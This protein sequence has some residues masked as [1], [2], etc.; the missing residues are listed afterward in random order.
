V[1][2]QTLL[3]PFQV[4]VTLLGADVTADGNFLYAADNQRGA[5]QGVIHKVDLTT[6]AVTELA[7]DANSPSYPMGAA[8][9]P[10]GVVLAANGKGFST[11]QPDESVLSVP[12]FQ[13]DPTTG[14]VTVRPDVPGGSTDTITSVARSADRSLL[15]FADGPNLQGPI[16]TYNSATDTFS[17][18][19]NTGLLLN[20]LPTAVNRNGTLVALEKGDGSLIVADASTFN[21]VKTLSGIDS[22]VAFDPTRDVLYGVDSATD[23]IVAFNTNTWAVVFTL[24]VGEPVSPPGKGVGTDVL[25]VSGDG[26]YLFLDT[27]SGVRVYPVPT[28]NQL[29][30]G[31]FTSPTTA[32]A[33]GSIT[34]TAQDSNGNVL[35]GYAGTVQF[36]STDPQA[37]LPKDY[38]F[39]PGDNGTHTF[40]GVVLRTA[41]TQSINVTDNG[42]PAL[43]GG[44]TNITVNAAAAASLTLSGVPT[45]FPSGAV[46]SIVV[47]AKDAYGNVAT[48]YT[49]K[50]R[51]TSTDPQ[52]SA[53]SGLPAGYT[54]TTGTGGD[55][56]SHT[57][58]NGLS[59]KTL[60][61]QTVTVTDGTLQNTASANVIGGA[62]TQLVVAV[63]PPTAVGP[64]AAFSLTVSAEDPNGNVDPLFT[65][66]VSLAL[67]SNP[68]G[69]TLGGTTIMNA[70]KGVAAFTGL[71]LD[72]TGTG[73]TI[74]ATAT[75]L[76]TAT[77]NPFD[78]DTLA[79]S[80]NTVPEFRPVGTLVGTLTTPGAG[81]FT[82]SLPNGSDDNDKFKISGNQLQTNDAFAAAAKSS[83]SVLVTSTDGQGPPVQQQFTITVTPDSALSLS[84]GTLTVSGKPGNDAFSF[85]AGLP[86]DG[87]TLDG[88]ALAVDA[89]SVAQ[90]GVVFNGGG[91]TDSATLFAGGGANA[92][93]LAPGGGTLSGPGGQVTVNGVAQV[94]VFGHAN[95][96]ATFYGSAG[97]D[98]FMGTPAF[99]FLRGAG[100]WNQANG[101]GVAV[102]VGGGGSDSAYLYG[103][104]GNDAF[105]GNPDYAFLNGAGFWN[106]VN[107]F[108]RVVGTAGPGGNDTANLAGAAQGGNT[109]VGTP[110]YGYLFGA[111]FLDFAAGFQ[112]VA[113][114]AAGPNNAA[115]LIG[116]AAGVNTLTATPAFA[117]LSGPGYLNYAAGFQTVT[118]LAGTANDVAQ[119]FDAPGG[120]F[121]ATATSAYV[122]AGAGQV[123]QAVGFRMVYGY[124]GGGDSAFLYGTMS[125][126][127]TYVNNGSYAFLFGPGFFVLESGFPSV[128]ANPFA[129]R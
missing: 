64:G 81:P 43:S 48:G 23:Q 29:I 71:T 46:A 73:Y 89:A 18:P 66:S 111:G 121:V 126:A 49:G 9:A 35:T 21:V 61:N 12:L 88:T 122:S 94:V 116:S 74:Q 55:N 26:K 24:A 59:L 96:R 10:Y 90:G 15:F 17:K 113:A 53:G 68:G 7:Y 50:V 124:S 30:V 54:F 58:T 40:T 4:G 99:A 77:T 56:G 31:G 25:A 3:A 78:V 108:S 62:A 125:A 105:V 120:M 95:D 67:A 118:A 98:V 97:D 19:F 91:G 75:N 107:S 16:F 82:Y 20:G 45:T 85:T 79:L 1:A 11:V 6:G 106:Q 13:I 72:K 102:G 103:G 84:N 8:G 101:F 127:D 104:A 44:E 100:F 27:T 110:T 51:F 34:V 47:T 87:M 112:T 114:T 63:Q 117:Q 42:S 128:W 129:R 33:G 69:A 5:T 32:G 36:T 80:N 39:G 60:G 2:N 52:A 37:V 119:L 14:A 83:Y 86:Q 70:A 76:S 115:I 123:E 22:G 28:T 109:F 93:V 41:G 65:G 92:L 38:T 57:F